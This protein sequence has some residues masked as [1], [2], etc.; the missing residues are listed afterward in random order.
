[1]PL[2]A[3]TTFQYKYLRKDAAGNAVWESGGNR[4]ATVGTTGALTLDDTWRG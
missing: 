3:G 1:M 2:P 4:T